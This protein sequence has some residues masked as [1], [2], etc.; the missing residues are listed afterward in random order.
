MA[1]H[2]IHKLYKPS[3]ISPYIVGLVKPDNDARM[4]E[5]IGETNQLLLAWQFER[6][7]DR[8]AARIELNG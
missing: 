2:E 4:I 6:N 3:R 1:V 8:I 7:E 5:A